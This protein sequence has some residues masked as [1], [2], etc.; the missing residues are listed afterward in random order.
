MTPDAQPTLVVK[1]QAVLFHAPP[2]LVV[3]ARKR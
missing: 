3:K 2:T 1:V